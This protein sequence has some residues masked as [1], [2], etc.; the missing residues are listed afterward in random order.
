MKGRH[1][2]ALLGGLLIG[3]LSSLPVVNIANVCCCLWV[4]V[5]GVLTVYLQQQNRP[6]PVETADAVVGGLIAGLIGALIASLSSFLQMA[7]AG[8]VMQ[9][10]IQQMLEQMQE[11]PPE[12]RESITRFTT[13]KNLALLTLVVNLPVFAVFGML[14]SLLGLSIFKKKVPVPPAPPPQG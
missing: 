4:V 1:A 6:D 14:G 13:G 9:D 2:P 7:I 8:P 10:S 12:L 11:L 3:V 5:G